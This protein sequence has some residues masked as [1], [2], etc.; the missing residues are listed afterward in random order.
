V[1]AG[2]GRWRGRHVLVNG[3]FADVKCPKLT[4]TISY[5]TEQV[6][7]AG[8]VLRARRADPPV[9]GDCSS[10]RACTL[11]RAAYGAANR[12]PASGTEPKGPRGLGRDDAI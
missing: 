5:D 7:I 3:N 8:Q 10:A 11:A 1:S 12:S 9:R 4:H 6:T 2:P